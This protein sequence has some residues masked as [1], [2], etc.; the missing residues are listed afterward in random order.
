MPKNTN[1]ALNKTFIK[2]K[3]TSVKESDP[4][5]TKVAMRSSAIAHRSG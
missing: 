2:S 4:G 3:G 1:L 5:S